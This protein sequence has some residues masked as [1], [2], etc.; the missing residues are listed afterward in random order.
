MYITTVILLKFEVVLGGKN[1]VK[2]LLVKHGNDTIFKN[3]L[4]SAALLLLQ[5]LDDGLQKFPCHE[6]RGGLLQ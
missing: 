4:I 5:I 6:V 1:N 3:L 2:E